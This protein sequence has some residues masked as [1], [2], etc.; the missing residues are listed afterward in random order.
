V[1]LLTVLSAEARAELEQLVD[2]RVRE[3]VDRLLAASETRTASPYM[4]VPEA[5]E[6]L[7]CT[8][9]RIYDLLSARRLRRFKDGSRVL[10]SRAEL[11]EHLA[12]GG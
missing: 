5:A 2:A 6:Y 4:T 9:Q 7:R 8:R 10:I 11:D 12:R 3:Q 1:S